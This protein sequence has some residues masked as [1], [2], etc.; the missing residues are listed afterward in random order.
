MWFLKLISVPSIEKNKRL[1]F[2]KKEKRN[3][4]L[5]KIANDRDILVRNKKFKYKKMNFSSKFTMIML[6]LHL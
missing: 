5:L 6:L 3:V 2:D 1:F 4:Q